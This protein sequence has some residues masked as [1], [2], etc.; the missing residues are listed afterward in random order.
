MTTAF[1]GAQVSLAWC[2]FTKGIPLPGE[3]MLSKKCFMSLRKGF[4]WDDCKGREWESHPTPGQDKKGNYSYNIFSFIKVIQRTTHTH[5][6][7]LVCKPLPL[8]LCFSFW[9][10]AAVRRLMSIA[11]QLLWSVGLKNEFRKLS[12][13]VWL[14]ECYRSIAVQILSPAC[15]DQKKVSFEEKKQV[16]TCLC[17]SQ[18]QSHINS[19][20]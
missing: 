19:W 11:V 20:Q 10:N 14:Q 17:H 5:T 8:P 9:W 16:I 18:T 13:S 4:L 3:W 15:C 6:V 12:P 1:S 2:I 7:L